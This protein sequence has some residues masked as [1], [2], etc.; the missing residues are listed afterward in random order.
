MVFYKFIFR[1]DTDRKPAAFREVTMAQA[2]KDIGQFI[3]SL[4]NESYEN[5]V[6]LAEKEALAMERRCYRGV[7]VDAEELVLCRQY[8]EQL[9]EFIVFIRSDVAQGVVGGNRQ[10]LLTMIK[11]RR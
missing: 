9:K 1:I 10:R 3:G 7:D 6:Y 8:A 5:I 2:V 4:Q 11:P